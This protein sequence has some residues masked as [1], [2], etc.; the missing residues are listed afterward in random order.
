MFPLGARVL[1]HKTGLFG[2][3]T[4]Y[5]GSDVRVKWDGEEGEWMAYA[6]DVER[7]GEVAPP[8]RMEANNHDLILQFARGTEALQLITRLTE[9]RDESKRRVSALLETYNRGV[10]DAQQSCYRDMTRVIGEA[11]TRLEGLT[12]GAAKL[13][14]DDYDDD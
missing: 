3:V 13:D 14:D 4:G 11:L 12:P 9:L 8:P 2:A 7:V 6:R 5:A 10:E 1:H